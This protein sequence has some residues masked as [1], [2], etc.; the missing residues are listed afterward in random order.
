MNTFIFEYKESD[1][2]KLLLMVN[3]NDILDA[4]TKLKNDGYESER[5]SFHSIVPNNSGGYVSISIY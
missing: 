4:I 1:K 2:S 3:G 5:L